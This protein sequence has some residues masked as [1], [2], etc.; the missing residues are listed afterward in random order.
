MLVSL[1]GRHVGLFLTVTTRTIRVCRF[2]SRLLYLDGVFLYGSTGRF[3]TVLDGR[4]R[5][6][7][8]V[9]YVGVGAGEWGPTLSLGCI[10]FGYLHGCGLSRGR[11]GREGSVTYTVFISLT[12]NTCCASRNLLTRAISSHEGHEGHK[13]FGYF[14]VCASFNG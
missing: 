7:R 13:G 12:S 14:T 3:V 10:F 1:H 2:V 8:G 11:E 4:F 9:W 5:Y 6:R